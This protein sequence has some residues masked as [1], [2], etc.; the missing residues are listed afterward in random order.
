MLR[1]TNEHWSICA[2]HKIGRL[3]ELG[4]LT[5]DCQEIFEADTVQC[6]EFDDK[7]S[8]ALC[9]VNTIEQEILALVVPNKHLNHATT[10]IQKVSATIVSWNRS[11]ELAN[12]NRESQS[13]A[14][15]LELVG[16]ISRSNSVKQ[17]SIEMANQL[18]LSGDLERV[19]IGVVTGGKLKL[20]TISGFI[21]IDQSSDVKQQFHQALLES[22]TRKRAGTYPP[23]DDNNDHQLLAHQ[24]LSAK[25]NGNQIFSHP[26][27]TDEGQTVGAW[28]LVGKKDPFQ[29]EALENWLRVVSPVIANALSLLRRSEK[30]RVRRGVSFLRKN[31]T[32]FS[33]L[34]VP[35]LCAAIYFLVL[36]PV[37]YRVRC[38][39][40]VEPVLKRYAV[41]PFDGMVSTS[42]ARPGDEVEIGQTVAVLDGLPIRWELAGITSQKQQALRRRE[43]EL[44]NRNI[45]KAFLSEL[46]FE[47]LDAKEEILKN[48]QANLEI[49]SPIKGVILSGSDEQSEA[50]SVSKGQVLFEIGPLSPIKIQVAIPANE[51][52][53]TDIGTT[54]KVW[55]EG[56][57]DKTLTGQIVRI[58]PRSQIQ[59]SANVFIAEI[60]L[61]NEDH[62]LR[63]GM[64][65]S[66]RIDCEKRTLGWCLFHKP[67]DFFRS[68]ILCW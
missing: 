33:W 50:A 19:A 54:A 22:Q 12:R 9:P 15:A 4:H 25:L 47:K 21:K 46:E 41:A 3:F 23:T 31:T 67:V 6:E 59:D 49:K 45:S 55:I 68:Q 42:E 57:E 58:N 27:T 28:L 26:L 20:E 16:T 13:L 24:Q 51:I 38:S 5:K 18:A 37:T 65:G 48:K 40:T 32:L 62:G 53:H 14:S 8:I 7:C 39:G 30:G 35:I 29:Q 10:I 52:P 36:I 34:M 66:V 56:H 64:K 1:R 63:P 11:I 43:I 60:E 2:E 44:A 61:P 17:A